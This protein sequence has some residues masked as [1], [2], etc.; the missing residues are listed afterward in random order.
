MRDNLRTVEAIYAAFARGDVKEILS[1]LADGVEWDADETSAQREGVPWLQ[2]KR[3]PAAVAQFFAYVGKWKFNDFRVLSLL[4]GGNQ[5]ASEIVIDAEVTQT[6]G[7]LR[8]REMHLWTF[9]G[10]GRVAR[11]QHHCDTGTHIA[12]WRG[13]R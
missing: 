11:F 1:M 8:Q 2:A 10:N 7:R 4:G 9:D 12:A 6:G 3:G 5:V 13:G